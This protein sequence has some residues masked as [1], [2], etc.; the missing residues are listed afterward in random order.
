VIFNRSGGSIPASEIL[1]RLYKKPVILTGF[2]L[3]DD[4]I[5]APDEN[6]DEGMF[7][8][9]IDALERIYNV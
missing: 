6:F 4:N 2:T 7:F 1:Q 9:G 3:P 5:H 8:L